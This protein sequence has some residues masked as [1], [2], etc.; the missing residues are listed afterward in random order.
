MTT[1]GGI[2]GN[3]G[4]PYKSLKGAVNVH[5]ADV[6]NVIVNQYVHQDTAVIS[7]IAVDS[8]VNDYQIELVDATGFAVD[9]FI[10]VNTTNIETTHPKIISVVLNVLTLDR[11]LDFAHST[12]D[13]V[14]KVIVDMALVGQV[15]SIPA[16]QLYYGGPPAGVVWHITR[17]LFSM[18]HTSAGDLG[19]FGNLGALIN[20]VLLRVKVNGQYGTLTNW[21]TNADMKT[22]MFDVEFDSRSGGGGDFGTSGRGTFTETGAVMRLDGDNGDQFEVHVQDNITALG[23]FAMKIQGHIEGD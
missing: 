11:R 4:G 6:H 7:T 22:D 12:G 5:I 13:S 2:V 17:L 20:G 10:H 19:K 1:T 23:F 3:N 14:N 8:L 16:H 15:G 18:T 9:D 21:K